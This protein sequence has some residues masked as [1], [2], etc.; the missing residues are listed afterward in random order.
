MNKTFEE[1]SLW[2]C[3]V[4]EAL[5]RVVN[6]RKLF[7]YCL[8]AFSQDEGFPNLKKQIEKQD[9]SNAFTTAHT[10]KGV[11]GNLSLIPLY[12]SISII[13]EALRN[14]EYEEING[15]CTNVMEK[16]DSFRNIIAKLNA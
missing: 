1:L 11:A 15:M 8:K 5:N 6:D 7:I 2:G 4:D 10:L 3:K 14:K 12:K 9:Y 16:Y 13:V